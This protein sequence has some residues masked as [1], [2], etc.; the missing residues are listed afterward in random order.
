MFDEIDKKIISILK[1][2]ARTP[3]SEI[4]ARINRSRTAVQ[5][6]VSKLEATGAILGYTIR[7]SGGNENA[8]TR[9]MVTIYLHERMLPDSV[10]ALLN[11]YSEVR[12]CH[13]ISG[14]AD[15]LV[16][17]GDATHDRIQELCK[18]LWSHENV[19]LTD[20]VFVLD[21]LSTNE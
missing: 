1:E 5:A 2:N 13:R 10:L 18:T 8:R 15:L 9:A 7:Q 4:A 21:T 11:T 3:L 19:R 17:I 6:R 14:D 16:E 12:H 20:T